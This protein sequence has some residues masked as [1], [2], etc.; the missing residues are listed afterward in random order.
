[1]QIFLMSRQI[2][3]SP[4]YRSI[5]GFKSSRNS[6]NN[7]NNSNSSNNRLLLKSL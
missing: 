7:S 5:M 6:R 1:M 2:L 3:F 4:F